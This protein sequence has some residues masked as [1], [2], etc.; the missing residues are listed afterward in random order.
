M[1]CLFLCA[2]DDESRF[3]KL[4]DITAEAF[5]IL[6]DAQAKLLGDSFI[7]THLFGWSWVP[8]GSG[9]SMS[10]DSMAM[11]SGDFFMEFYVPHIKKNG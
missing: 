9:A 11:I 1:S 8:E 4:M 7:G 10:V 6:W 3:N 2:Y 5:C